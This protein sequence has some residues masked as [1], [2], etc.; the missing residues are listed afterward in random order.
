MSASC[1]WLQLPAFREV[2]TGEVQGT[3]APL[4]LEILCTSMILLSIEDSV[5][6][7]AAV[8]AC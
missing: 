8:L 7:A 5:V 6:T 4:Q 3:S 2:S 1:I